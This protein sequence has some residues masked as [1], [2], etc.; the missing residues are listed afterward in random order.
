MSWVDRTLPAERSFEDV[1]YFLQI[2][3]LTFSAYLVA[4][5]LAFFVGT[6]SDKI[7]APF[8]PPNIVLLCA[9][10]LARRGWRWIVVLAAF[11]AHVI[12]E[13]RIGMSLSELLAAFATN[14]AV[15]ALSTAAIQH[16]LVER[17][18]FSNFRSTANFVFIVGF[19][20]PA[21]V[22]FG[23]AFVPI[24]GGGG[25]ENY[26]S[27]WTQWFASN[28]LGNLAL[29]PLALVLATEGPRAFWAQN[30]ERRTE[31]CLIATL[32]IVVCAIVFEQSAG[33]LVRSFLPA[34]FYLPVPLVLWAASRFGAKGASA[35]IVAMAVVLIW[36]SFGSS[37]FLSGTPESNVFA[38]QVFLISLAVP[39]LLLGSSIEEARRA[40]QQLRQD[41][42]RMAFAAAAADVGLWQHNS[43]TNPFWATDHCRAMLGLQRD[44]PVTRETIL[45]VVHP[46][47]RVL[48]GETI[49][50][51]HDTEAP[52]EFRIIKPDGHV[53]W[54]QA[55]RAINRNAAG[56]AISTS[57]VFTDISTRKAAEAEAELQRR[58]LA[59]L[60]RVSQVGALSGGL[61][62]E[63]TQ[64]LTAILANAQAARTMLS[65]KAP[66]LDDI[67][68]S[69]DDIISED[70]RAGE[71]IQRLRTLLKNGKAEVE[72][73]D[74]QALIDSTLRLLNNELISRNVKTK[75]IASNGLS[76]VEGDPV[77]IQQ[78]LLNLV[79]NAVEAM[80]K[81]DV[82]RRLLTL[83]SQCVDDRI[84]VKVID[85]GTGIDD[86][87]KTAL[88]NAFFTTKESGLG[89]GLSICSTII[90]RHGGSLSLSNNADGGA[91][92]RFCLPVQR[93][94]G[95]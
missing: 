61:A 91:T 3:L 90:E 55:K 8:W 72:T 51:I 33:Q 35:A 41:E 43:H 10:L 24:L 70:L 94:K 42:A 44:L 2:A 31:A 18:W 60:M 26:W 62:H 89:L 11:P 21:V 40:N 76:F 50:G 27:F 73:V 53:K 12:A 7:F 85:R 69:L 74:I 93:T 71:V 86:E 20:C 56:A 84:E 54:L 32:L 14:L 52:L 47:D 79:M 66:K 57:G 49:V 38:L 5:E 15:A 83:A 81:T 75:V 77:Q 4:A 34:L 22:A 92:A 37:L 67:A 23:G 19:V 59:H 58:E 1:K 48:V 9:L 80:I 64:P 63:L 16:R 36:R 46:D 87:A 39:M 68:S 95:A 17:P 25:V 65:A 28:A 88:F 82:R 29:G 78:V 13:M 45:S 6:L 30:A